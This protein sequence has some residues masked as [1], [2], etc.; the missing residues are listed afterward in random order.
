MKREGGVPM[1]WRLRLCVLF[2]DCHRVDATRDADTRPPGAGPATLAR[3]PKLKCGAF[4]GYRTLSGGGN[5][6]H[7]NV[8][9][10]PKWEAEPR[11][12]ST[13]DTGMTTHIK[14]KQ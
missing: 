4:R 12:P 14:F 10:P 8:D 9:E 6:Q 1:W 3:R 5:E 7:S 13:R 11:K 2:G